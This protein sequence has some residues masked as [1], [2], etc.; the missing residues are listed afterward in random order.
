MLYRPEVWWSTIRGLRQ[1]RSHLKAKTW[2][3]LAAVYPRTFIIGYAYLLQAWARYTT[4]DDL[5]RCPDQ[6]LVA[7]VFLRYVCTIDNRIDQVDSQSLSLATYERL[8]HL[9]EARTVARELC[10][11][12]DSLDL[13][14]APKMKMLRCIARYRRD[15]ATPLIAWVTNPTY[16]LQSV[17][18]A[19]EQTTG[20]LWYTWSRLL[21][22][23]F[24]VPDALAES[25]AKCF[26]GL[27]MMLQV[28][29]DLGDTP[30]DDKL[31]AQIFSLPWPVRYPMSVSGFTT[32]NGSAG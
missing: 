9:P 19:K 10:A 4:L 5:L 30:V 20:N 26:W 11:G 2:A 28:L 24:L 16:D 12:I 25:A 7:E 1:I 8:T 27:G 32:C 17:K 31:H 13:P 22:H 15:V 29:D 23:L 6:A 18:A 14:L 21:S 3:S